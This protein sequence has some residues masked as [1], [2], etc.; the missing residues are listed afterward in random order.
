M[1]P[2][3]FDRWFWLA[4][5]MEVAPRLPMPAKSRETLGIENK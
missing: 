3:I 2:A 5:G 1:I 4:R